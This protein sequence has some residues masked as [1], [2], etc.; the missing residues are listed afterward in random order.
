MSATP[1]VLVEISEVLSD[2]QRARLDRLYSADNDQRA[3][4]LFCS[5]C[6]CDALWHDIG[7]ERRDAWREAALAMAELAAKAN[8]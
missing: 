6:G 7:P 3:F 8:G 2:E 5:A 1:E 4:S